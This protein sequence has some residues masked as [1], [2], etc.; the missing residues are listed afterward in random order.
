MKHNIIG[1]I[2]ARGGS[3]GIPRKNLIKLMGKPLI[4]YTIEQGLESH[5]LNKVVVSTEDK[6]IANL[7]KSL[8]AEVPFLRPKKLAEDNVVSI[9]VVQHTLKKMEEIDKKKYNIIVLLQPTSPLRKSD[10]I[11][12]GIELLLRGKADS[13]VGVVRT[14]THPFRMKRVVNDGW[15]I[16]YIDQG[17]EDMRPRQT[18]P[19]V[20][21]RNGTLYISW[22]SVVLSGTMV[23]PNCMAYI[24]SK[25]RSIDI[26]SKFDLIIA[27]NILKENIK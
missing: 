16:N 26:D 24:M 2:P 13:V 3:K 19:P 22:R 6:E 1:I 12:N 7:S 11:D 8:G 20:Y 18:L 10:D 17:F 4:Q 25:E 5:Y 14:H 9:D 23:G 27:E 21:V 15:L